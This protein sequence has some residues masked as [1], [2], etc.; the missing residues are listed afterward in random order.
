MYRT[1]EFPVE[2]QNWQVGLYQKKAKA[3]TTNQ[4]IKGGGLEKSLSQESGSHVK[5]LIKTKLSQK[6]L[7]PSLL[8][9][10]LVVLHERGVWVSMLWILGGRGPERQGW[11]KEGG[12]GQLGAPRN[13][14]V[15]VSGGTHR[16]GRNIGFLCLLRLVPSEGRL[17]LWAA[18]LAASGQG[19][20]AQ[21]SD[22]CTLS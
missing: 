22:N 15:S 10:L 2:I 16:S 12:L 7:A 4:D 11:Q 1:G 6:W 14:W 18:V 17:Q 13:T 19:D 3:V 20:L 8:H 9:P 5:F 21:Q